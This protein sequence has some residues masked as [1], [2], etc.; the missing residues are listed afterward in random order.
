L[1]LKEALEIHCTLQ[2]NKGLRMGQRETPTI[3]ERRHTK[4]NLLQ[5][6]ETLITGLPGEHGQRSHGMLQ[7]GQYTLH[8]QQVHNV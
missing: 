5:K 3:I 1:K 8:A 6:L 7:D 2:N 4:E